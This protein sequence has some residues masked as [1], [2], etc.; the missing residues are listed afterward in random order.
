MAITKMLMAAVVAMG[1]G[2]SQTQAPVF[3][4]ATVKANLSGRAG[5]EFPAPVHGKLTVINASLK[6]LIAAAYSV[7]RVRVT[8]GP[9]WA[10]ADRFDIVAQGDASAS[11]R[12]V[13]QMLQGLLTERFGLVLHR[14]TKE[15]PVYA[16]TVA[17]GGSKLGKAVEGG[18]GIQQFRMRDGGGAILGENATLDGLARALSTTLDRPVVNRTGLIGSFDLHDLRW[19]GDAEKGPPQMEVRTEERGATAGDMPSIFVAIQE[20]L[21]LRL[22]SAKGPVELLVIDRAERPSGR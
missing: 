22:D 8:G 6:M 21:G 20:Q 11:A 13:W 16:L 10:S 4:V 1:V 5:W 19:S 3:E 7:D 14:E 9:G 12:Q 18:T 2:L 17:K 15:M